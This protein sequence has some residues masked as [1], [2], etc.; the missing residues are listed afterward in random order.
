MLYLNLLE[1]KVVADAHAGPRTEWHPGPHL[2]GPPLLV[3]PPAQ[4]CNLLKVIRAH[5]R[6]VHQVKN[7]YFSFRDCFTA[8]YAM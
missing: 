3:Q 2:G 4:S 5:D 8:L 7:F 6:A 1:G